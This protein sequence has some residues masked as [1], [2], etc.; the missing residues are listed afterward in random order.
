VP[1]RWSAVRKLAVVTFYGVVAILCFLAIRRS[2]GP[3]GLHGILPAFLQLAPDA[4]ILC[5]L[6]VIGAYGTLIIIERLTLSD[7]IEGRPPRL[8]LTPFVA[9]TLSL[10]AGLGPLSGSALRIRLYEPLGIGPTAAVYLATTTTI[11]LL[12]GGVIISAAGA[13]FGFLRLDASLGPA[14]AIGAATSLGLVGLVVAAGRRGRRFVIFKRTLRLASSRALLVRMA[15]AAFNWACTAI[16]LYVLL[17]GAAQ[18]PLL[19]F[20][21]TVS[22]LKLASLMTGAPGGL[23]V[24]EALMLSLIGATIAPDDLTAALIASRILSFVAP[25]MLAGIGAVVLEAKGN[26]DSWSG[27]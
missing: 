14:Q 24:F 3:S 13:A 20:V 11:V 9:T 25:V 2:L 27:V 8:V 4:L 16:G 26:R 22:V 18:P 21:V 6:T 10:G 23:G 17:P 1:A 7:V 19:E 5:G 12:S 15:L